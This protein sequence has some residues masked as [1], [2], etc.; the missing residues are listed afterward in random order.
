LGAP[1]SSGEDYAILALPDHP[2]PISIRTHSSDPV[3]FALYRKGDGGAK[4]V[5]Y[6]ESDAKATNVMINEGYTLI[7]LLRG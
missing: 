6:N 2:T 4:A 5:K 1:G 7:D 3:P